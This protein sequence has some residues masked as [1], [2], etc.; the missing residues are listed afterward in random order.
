M[1]RLPFVWYAAGPNDANQISGDSIWI[2]LRTRKL[3]SI[4]IRGRAVAISRAD[5]IHPKRFNQMTGQEIAM[6]FAENR[7]QRIDVDRTAT[8]LYYLFDGETPNGL[9]TTTGDRVTMTFID[10]AIDKIAVL[11]DV[12]G[13]YVPERLVKG[14]E[15]QYNLEGFN[16]RAKITR[17]SKIT[18]SPATDSRLK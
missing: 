8:S 7:L 11:A 4:L 18:G 15:E 1:R 2:Q 10:G 6:R 9:N 17:G 5:S 13:Q 3:E 14:R 16:W 12:Q